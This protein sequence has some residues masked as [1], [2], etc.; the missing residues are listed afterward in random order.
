MFLT[1]I[2]AITN[3][4]MMMMMMT[5]YASTKCQSWLSLWHSAISWKQSALIFYKI[6]L[7]SLPLGKREFKHGSI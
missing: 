4:H 7:T 3:I 6:H 2:G 1:V 5:Q